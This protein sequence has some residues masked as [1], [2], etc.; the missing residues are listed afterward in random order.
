MTREPPLERPAGLPLAIAPV[1]ALT[2]RLVTEIVRHAGM[3]G[4]DAAGRVGQPVTDVT[5]SR[6]AR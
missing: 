4:I 2:Y 5:L 3:D 1:D 6:L